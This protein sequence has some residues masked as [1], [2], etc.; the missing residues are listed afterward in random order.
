MPNTTAIDEID[1][2]YC[3]ICG[4]TLTSHPPKYLSCDKCKNELYI[5]A[6][7]CNAVILADNLGRILL[8]K[9]KFEPGKDLWDLPGGFID[10][11]ETAEMSVQREMREELGIEV[12]NIRYLCSGPDRY[13][14]KGVNY[15]TL[16]FVFT[17]DIASGALSARDDVSTFQFFANDEIPWDAL[18]FPVLRETLHIFFTRSR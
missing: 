17:A 14:F 13:E 2:S 15:H 10:L 11:N 9:R 8:T 7:P 6:R 5:N 4:E 3:P 12:K 16:G 18:A 1:F